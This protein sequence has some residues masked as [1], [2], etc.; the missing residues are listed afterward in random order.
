[1]IRLKIKIIFFLIIILPKIANSLTSSSYLIANA[2]FSSFDFEIA[3]RYFNDYDYTELGT[4]ELRKKIIH[5][6]F[7]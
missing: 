3:S 5:S 6:H 1:M 7:I 4:E 2:A